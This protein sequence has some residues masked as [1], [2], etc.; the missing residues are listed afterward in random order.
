M[1]WM[2]LSEDWLQSSYNSNW[3]RVVGNLYTAKVLSPEKS[4]GW[5]KAPP[6]PPFTSPGLS[7]NRAEFLL[8]LKQSEEA[9]MFE[10]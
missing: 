3:K 7:L 2:I 8:Y 1:P 4:W 5:T 6:M 10:K 9:E